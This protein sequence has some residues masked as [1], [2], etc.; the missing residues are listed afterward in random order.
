[1]SKLVALGVGVQMLYKV[2]K[3]EEGSLREKLAYVG[4]SL[5]GTHRKYT[6]RRSF[7]AFIASMGQQL[8]AF[9]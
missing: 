7:G 1:M 8:G 3:T 2:A 9:A 6:P 5:L 4:A